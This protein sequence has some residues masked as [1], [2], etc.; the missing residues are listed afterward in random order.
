M[1]ESKGVRTFYCD[2]AGCRSYCEIPGSVHED[3]TGN[4]L[5]ARG[6]RVR[7]TQ[8]LCPGHD[9]DWS[10]VPEKAKVPDPV[11]E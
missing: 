11:E 7:G 6:W 4:A 8:H 5:E 3:D 9:G 10:K 2:S 1:S